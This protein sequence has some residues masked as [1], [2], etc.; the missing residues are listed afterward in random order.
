MDSVAPERCTKQLV[1][2]VAKSARFHSDQ[3]KADQS[4]AEN[5][6][7]NIDGIKSS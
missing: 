3:Q 6:F 1:L 4:I 5:V 7:K 2:T